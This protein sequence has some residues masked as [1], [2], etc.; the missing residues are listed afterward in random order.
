MVEDVQQTGRHGERCGRGHAKHLESE[1]KPKPNKDDADV[2][3]RVVRKQPLE[4]VLH[5]GVEHA[6]QGGAGPD[7]E[8]RNAPP[9]AGRPREFKHDP[10]EA[11]D[12]DLRHDPAHQ[13]GDMARRRRVSERQPNMQRHDPRLRPRADQGQNEGEGG[14][15]GRRLRRA[16]GVE[17]VAAGGTCEQSEGE[18]QHERAEARRDE[19]DIA[20][21]RVVALAM[22]GHHQRP[23]GDRHELPGQQKRIG[24]VGEKDDVHAGEKGGKERQHAFRRM[25]VTRVSEAIEARRGSAEIDDDEEERRQRVDTEVRAD[26]RQAERQDERL[27]VR[28]SQKL[29]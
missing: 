21:A 19:V 7:R 2:L 11:V 18:Q 3:D 17:G 28:V 20:G 1:R 15:A 6:E 4:V 8:D 16:H 12:G 10:D 25:F 9:P 22:M 13:R 14:D 29:D 24:V 23:R 5:Q 27:P 26:P